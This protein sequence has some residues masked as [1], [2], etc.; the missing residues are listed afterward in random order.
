M[1]FQAFC[2]AFLCGFYQP[3]PVQTAYVTYNPNFY[4]NI[5]YTT[6]AFQATYQYKAKSIDA[7][8]GF[9]LS[10][11]NFEISNDL[12]I[13]FVNIE[14]FGA[15]FNCIYHFNTYDN[16]FNEHDLI[17]GAD[18]FFKPTDWFTIKFRTGYLRT[19]SEIFALRKYNNEWITNN[20][21]Y[22]YLKTQ[23]EPIENLNLYLEASNCELF[24][25]MLFSSASFTIGAEY[26]FNFGLSI[27]AEAV[28][29]YIDIIT[30]SARYDSTDLRIS[31]GYR[32]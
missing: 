15:G 21:V 30:L 24:K 9:K 12:T 10:E 5:D 4:N 27:K 13:Y 32:W 19:S 8:A 7:T 3:S 17:L 2:L 16:T 23:F 29:R 26:T 22:L 1:T 18:V 25:Y 31:A 28:S 11:I 6:Q 20:S 14:K